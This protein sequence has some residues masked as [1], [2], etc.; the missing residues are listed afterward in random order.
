MKSYAVRGLV[1]IVALS[2]SPAIADQTHW[3]VV[4]RSSSGVFVGCSDRLAADGS[5]ASPAKT[6]ERLGVARDRSHKG[7]E[8]YQNLR[9]V[10]DTAI[11]NVRRVRVVWESAEGKFA[12]SFFQS[13]EDCQTIAK[14][15][16]EAKAWSKTG[17]LESA[18]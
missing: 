13:L 11:E 3:W 12:I 18:K 6:Y 7:F 2:A 5:A 8:R 9:I 16:R 10:E 14:A 17:K 15:E 4:A 1:A